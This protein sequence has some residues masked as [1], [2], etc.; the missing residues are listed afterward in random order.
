MTNRA[1][2]LR[3]QYFWGIQLQYS[4]SYLVRVDTPAAVLGAGQERTTAEVNTNQSVRLS[5]V[6]HKHTSNLCDVQQFGLCVGTNGSSPNSKPNPVE[7][8]YN[9]VRGPQLT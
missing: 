8:G 6:R 1:Q 4:I 2:E 5:H 7:G 3:V 9:T